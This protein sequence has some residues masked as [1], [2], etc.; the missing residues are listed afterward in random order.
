MPIEFIYKHCS[1]IFGKYFSGKDD[2][3]EDKKNKRG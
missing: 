2:K 3:S 1:K